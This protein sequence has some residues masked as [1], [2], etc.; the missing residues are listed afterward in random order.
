MAL[1]LCAVVERK[2]N[3]F[4]VG[5]IIAPDGK[6]DTIKE[7]IYDYLEQEGVLH[8]KI[9]GLGSDGAAMMMGHKTGVGVQLKRINTL[10][11]HIHFCAHRLAL[12]VSQAAGEVAAIKSFE[13]TIK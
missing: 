11:A 12:A 6:A 8:W 5:N 13:L 4:F 2:L 3:V 9:I 7:A 10:M 1:L